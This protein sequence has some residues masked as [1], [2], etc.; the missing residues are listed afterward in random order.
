M[1]LK[2]LIIGVAGL[3][4]LSAAVVLL[5]RQPSD[6]DAADPRVGTALVDP[7][8]AGDV[9]KVRLTGGG[10]TVTLARQADGSWRVGEYFDL[11]ADFS[12]LSGLV[13]SLTEGK[14]ER[15]VTA[16]PD[17]IARLQFA[18][19]RVELLDGAD[20][21]IAGVE[22]GRYAETGGGRYIRF[23]GDGRAYE[24]KWGNWIDVEARNWAD[25]QLLDVSENDVA[26]VEIG[27]AG[28]GSVAVARTKATEPWAAE[29][30]LA[31]RTVKAGAVEALLAAVGRVHFTD[32][33]DVGDAGVA[34]ARTHGRTV[35][36]R[37]FAGKTYTVTLAR[38][39]ETRRPKAAP[40]GAAKAGAAKGSE[41]KGSAAGGRTAGAAKASTEAPAVAP[42]METIPAG[43]VYA[44]IRCDNAS[45][46]VNALMQ[47]RAFE[48]ADSVLTSVPKVEGDIVEAGVA[49]ETNKT[50]LR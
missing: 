41:A 49:V 32:T 10:K 25:T 30:R 46:P 8:R 16:S 20:K 9:A 33:K 36:F 22:L 21:A 29:G 26:R 1:K 45:A 7:A 44:S 50:A 13:G 18:G 42:E 2:T 3:A 39:P 48:V 47:K 19:T 4:A 12:K 34:A 14:V 43:P 24:T 27:L 31:G 38:T 11:P 15:F 17:R 37:T 23:G 6:T 5:Q 40:A 35:T 28:G